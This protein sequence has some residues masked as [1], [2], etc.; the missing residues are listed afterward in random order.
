MADNQ[1]AKDIQNGFNALA[2]GVKEAGK[3]QMLKEVEEKGFVAFRKPEAVAAFHSNPDYFDWTCQF[4]DGE[5]R[6][7]PPKKS[8]L[9]FEK[10]EQN[11]HPIPE[12]AIIMGTK[13]IVDAYKNAVADPS[14]TTFVSVSGLKEQPE[15]I[16][17]RLISTDKKT[18]KS[19]I[20]QNFKFNFDGKFSTE[21]LPSIYNQMLDGIPAEEYEKDIDSDRK[22]IVLRNSK[23]DQTI[24]FG[25]ITKDQ[26]ELIKNMKG[27]VDSQ[28]LNLEQEQS[29]SI[30]L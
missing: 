20:L 24:G 10:L 18:G 6:F 11:K 19:K 28:Y 7:Y 9:I 13:D 25:N 30:H 21:V 1:T 12:N 8:E 29:N 23:R 26:A 2:G 16:V 17:Y 3:K 5:Y 15:N 14:T 27:F 4:V 22:H